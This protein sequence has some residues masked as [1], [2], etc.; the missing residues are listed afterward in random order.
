M[1]SRGKHYK[2]DYQGAQWVDVNL[3]Q[4]GENWLLGKHRSTG[5]DHDDDSSIREELHALY[6]AH[7]W[8]WPKRPVLFFSDLHADADAL[9][10]SLVASGGIKKTGAQDKDFKLTAFGRKARF[11]IGGDCFDKGP[12]NLRL[13]RCL[14]LLKK[15]GARLHILAGNHDIRVKLGLQS[16]NR[17]QDPVSEHLFV[18]MGAKV[19]PL[20]KEI[21]ENYLTGNNSLRDIPDTDECRRRLYPSA[22]WFEDFPQQA[23]WLMPEKAIAKELK[24]LT[25]KTRDFEQDC[26]KAG[27]SLRMVYAAALTWQELFLQPKGEFYW[28]FKDMRLLLKKGSFLFVHAGI[29]DRVARLIN[30]NGAKYINKQFR[31]HVQEGMSEFYYG[32]FANSVRTKYREVDMPLTR[33]GVRTLKNTGIQV[34]VHGHKNLHHGQRIM[35]R[36]GFINFECDASVDRNTRKKEGLLRYGAAVTIFHPQQQALGISTDYPYIKVFNPAALS[37]QVE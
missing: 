17:T 6:Q 16:V 24:R 18:R 36:K 33:H 12:S 29:D 2:P 11:V 30:K 22:S 27:L 14:Y 20:L 26:V 37:E 9:L 21:Q 35:L 10:A 19:I 23:K 15:R 28:Y 1:K 34:I 4:Q 5:K 25:E 32:P 31:E 8:R 7:P 3:P 13:L